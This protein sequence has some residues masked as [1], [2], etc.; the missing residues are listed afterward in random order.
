MSQYL[1][2]AGSAVL[3]GDVGGHQSGMPVVGHKDHLVSI[4]EPRRRP[5]PVLKI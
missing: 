5:R 4:G 1:V 2:D 3:A